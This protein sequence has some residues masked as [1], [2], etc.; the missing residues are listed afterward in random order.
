MGEAPWPGFVALQWTGV[1]R[2]LP[3]FLRGEG[4]RLDIGGR[5]AHEFLNYN[6]K[7]LKIAWS[8]AGG[9]AR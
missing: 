8:A 4:K 3:S 6:I 5:R 9:A 1:R 7:I 2:R